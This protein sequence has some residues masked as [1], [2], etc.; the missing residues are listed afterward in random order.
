[1]SET[2]TVRSRF[3]VNDVVYRK[4]SSTE[5]KGIVIEVRFGIGGEVRYKVMWDGMMYSTKHYEQELSLTYLP[6]Y[7]TEQESEEC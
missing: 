7:D 6:S 4:I 5:E 3:W 1:M 2:R